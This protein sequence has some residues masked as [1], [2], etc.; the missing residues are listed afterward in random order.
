M[1]KKIEMYDDN[2]ALKPYECLVKLFDTSGPLGPCREM[3]DSRRN[4]S[5]WPHQIEF[6]NE[7]KI[8]VS[9]LEGVKS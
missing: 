6:S 7:C 2:K 8:E 4:D 5:G 1:N 3:S 9:G